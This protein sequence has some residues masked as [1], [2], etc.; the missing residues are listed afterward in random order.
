[1]DG[2]M[3][4]L[5][6]KSDWNKNLSIPSLTWLLLR[7]RSELFSLSVS[8]PIVWVRPPSWLVDSM[9][10]I[11]NRVGGVVGAEKLIHGSVAAKRADWRLQHDSYSPP[12]P[13]P[14]TFWTIERQPVY[15]IWTGL[16]NLRLHLY[17]PL[18]TVSPLSTPLL[19][20]WSTTYC[21][22]IAARE[23]IR[24]GACLQMEMRH[25]WHAR[26]ALERKWAD[27]FESPATGLSP[28]H[29]KRSLLLRAI[30]VSQC[31]A[32]AQ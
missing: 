14:N 17:L 24:L 21:Y 8:P 7:L 3:F 30:H 29:P 1:M 18:L 10:T 23:K 9:N 16:S 25:K 22:N 13:P 31:W 2:L 15:L 20:T 32:W 28:C 27:Y 11:I 12:T 6:F 19:W 4:R 26:R 5:H